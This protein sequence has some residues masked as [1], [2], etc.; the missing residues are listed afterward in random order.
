MKHF[1][2]GGSG[3][4]Q[5]LDHNSQ[6]SL[7]KRGHMTGGIS[8]QAC[9]TFAD[10]IYTRGELIQSKTYFSNVNAGEGSARFSHLPLHR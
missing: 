5:V 8:V 2:E 6:I 7:Q 9:L 3:V 4:P 1:R 10:V